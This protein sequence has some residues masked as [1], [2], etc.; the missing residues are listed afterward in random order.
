M[1]LAGQRLD[2]ERYQV[3]PRTLVFGF[4]DGRVLLERVPP[5]RGAWAGRWN[6]VGGHVE[7]GESPAAAAR[8][9]FHEE[10]GLTLT[11]LR[12]AGQVIVDLGPTAGIGISVFAGRVGQGQARGGEEGELAWF[13]MD[14]VQSAPTVED[15]PV[16]LARARACLDGDPP[17][18]AVYRYDDGRL[19]IVI[20]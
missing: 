3:V 11:A 7:R 10:T 9:E 8:R 6:G 14:E 17:F 16:L 20:D 18:T 5:G 19:S 13:S 4:R 12:L 15:V 2:P 1:S